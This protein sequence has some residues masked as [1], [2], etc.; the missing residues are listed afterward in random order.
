MIIEIP[1]LK[2]IEVFLA[3]YCPSP[4][5]CKYAGTIGPSILGFLVYPEAQG[6]NRSVLKLSGKVLLQ[7]PSSIVGQ[8]AKHTLLISPN[9]TIRISIYLK[10]NIFYPVFFEYVMLRKLKNTDLSL[11][12]IIQD[13]SIKYQ[14]NEDLIAHETLIKRYQRFEK[15]RLK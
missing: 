13:F 11:S 8:A 9:A 3:N 4:I 14:L 12:S 15:K 6:N 10:E 2:F 1:V 5:S 7:V